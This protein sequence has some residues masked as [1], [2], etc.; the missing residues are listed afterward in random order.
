MANFHFHAKIIGR[1]QGRSAVGSAAYRAGVVLVDRRPTINLRFD[2]T[3][4]KGIDGA[5]ILAPAGA[6]AWCSDRSELWNRVEEAEKRKDAQVCREVEFSLPVELS[7][8]E[9]K[10][11][12]RDFVRSQFVDAG[13]VADVAFHHLDSHNPHAHV[14]LTMRELSADGAGF[15]NKQRAWNEWALVETWREQWASHANAALAKSGHDARIDHRSLAEQANDAAQRGDMAAAQVLDRTP[16]IHEGGSKANAAYNATVIRAENVERQKAWNETA[17]QARA[18]ARLMAPSYDTAP[19]PPQLPR[20]AFNGQR[21]R[22]PTIDRAARDVVRVRKPDDGR[23]PLLAVRSLDMPNL[24][25]P[26]GR[27][28]A[29]ESIG[30][31]RVLRG[32]EPRHYGAGSP[33]QQLRA[34]AREPVNMDDLTEQREKRRERLAKLGTPPVAAA[35]R[36][37]AQGSSARVARAPR[38]PAVGGGSVRTRLTGDGT[39]QGEKLAKAGERWLRDLD[40]MVAQLIRTALEAARQHS[41]PW[42]RAKG[43][44]LL[45][46]GRVLRVRE[47]Q[48]KRAKVKHNDAQNSTVRRAQR[49]AGAEHDLETNRTDR[50][51]MK[52]TGAEPKR[53]RDLREKEAKARKKEAH[54]RKEREATGSAQKVAVQG[55]ERKQ[56]AFMATWQ[57][58]PPVPHDFAGKP[59]PKPTPGATPTMPP[60]P[61]AAPAPSVEEQTKKPRPPKL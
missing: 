23:Q 16:T 56:Q 36:P 27:G 5:E 31:G 32:D 60:A 59:Q 22:A 4:K 25:L 61:W 21:P 15:G 41:D 43:R 47:R 39:K 10:V 20:R 53:L 37:K 42:E 55:F 24:G 44:D 52:L 19:K 18:E 3:H 2:Y 33:V 29:A 51:M 40:D 35:A 7:R 34:E 46:S 30:A 58:N 45:T 6:P 14:L 9:M 8:D 26:S 1:S 28:R 12:A 13:M 17:E 49:R 38:P 11:L 50:L 54:T 48:H 57:K